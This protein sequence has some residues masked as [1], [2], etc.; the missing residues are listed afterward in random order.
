MKSYLGLMLELIWVL[1][2][3]LLM[4]LMMVYM[5]VHYWVVSAPDEN[6]IYFPSS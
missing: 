6:L 3:A 4:V 5:I 1:Q 2:M